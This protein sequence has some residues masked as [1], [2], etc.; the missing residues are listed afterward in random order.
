MTHLRVF[1]LPAI[2]HPATSL[3]IRGKGYH[4]LARVRRMKPGQQ[5]LGTD[6][7]GRY[8]LCTI[9]E[10][11]ASSLSV[12]LEPAP[13]SPDEGPRIC[14][15]QALPKGRKMDLIVR[16]AAEAGVWKIRPVFSRH[17]EYRLTDEEE[18]E[19]KLERWRRI[20]REAIQQSGS[21]ALPVIERPAAL[22]S[23][24]GSEDQ[25]GEAEARLFFHQERV[26]GDSLHGSL[27][28]KLKIITLVV[29]PEGGLA[30][31]EVALLRDRGFV[32][33]TLGS[34][35]LRAE[36]AALFAVAAVQAVAHERQAWK[37]V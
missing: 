31:E 35:V 18:V 1:V 6:G 37:L 9:G 36:T 12:S 29:G 7:Q 25:P 22:E 16:Q 17:S 34:S 28:K 11:R 19:R 5:F 21:Q 13:A 23:V 2:P 15:I 14:L 4:Y 26:S 10:I 8:Y 33:V 24:V 27:S 3:E 32:P 30:D 20:A